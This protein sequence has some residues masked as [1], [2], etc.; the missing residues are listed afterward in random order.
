VTPIGDTA[1]GAA[2][3]RRGGLVLNAQRA[4]VHFALGTRPWA[5]RHIERIAAETA[6]KR[7]LEI[8]SGGD[9]RS[10]RG[11]FEATNEFVQSDV[12]PDFGHRVLDVT[13]ME[14]ESEFDLLLCVYVLE[15]VFDVRAATER[16]HRALVPGGRAFIVVPAIYPYHDEPTDYWRFTEYSMRELLRPF[17]TVEIRHRGLRRL[18]LALLAEATK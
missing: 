9:M 10:A 4:L 11:L 17:G 1:S 3:S 13:T 16:I 5:Y 7:V 12:V 6:G 14:F 18:P 8:G 15:H 2:P